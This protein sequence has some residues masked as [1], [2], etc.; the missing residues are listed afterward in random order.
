MEHESLSH[1]QAVTSDWHTGKGAKSLLRGCF[2]LEPTIQL[3]SQDAD[4]A[5]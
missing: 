1:S 3:T 4:F 5:S 2:D